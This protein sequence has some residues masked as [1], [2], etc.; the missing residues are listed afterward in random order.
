MF[1]LGGFSLRAW[2]S[3][4]VTYLNNLTLIGKFL[5]HEIDRCIENSSNKSLR[6][7]SSNKSLRTY[8]VLFQLGVWARPI[9]GK[10]GL[11]LVCSQEIKNSE[12]WMSF[13]GIRS[14]SRP[15]KLIFRKIFGISSPWFAYNLYIFIINLY[16]YDIRVICT[17]SVTQPR[18]TYIDNAIGHNRNSSWAIIINSFHANILV[19]GSNAFSCMRWVPD[20]HYVPLCLFYFEAISHWIP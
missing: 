18:A 15:G 1:S 8:S 5:G 13:P 3:L 19:P 10:L 11:G 9:S 16:I 4:V 12:K 7:C 14:V 2:L 20:F 17:F 6:T